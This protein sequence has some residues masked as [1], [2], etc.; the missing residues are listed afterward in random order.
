MAVYCNGRQFCGLI[1]SC[2]DSEQVVN[3]G[4]PQLYIWAI[5]AWLMRHGHCLLCSARNSLLDQDTY[6]AM[7]LCFLLLQL[8][9]DI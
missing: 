6:A 8:L 5:T 4:T 2:L 1:S 9:R 3:T 7:N